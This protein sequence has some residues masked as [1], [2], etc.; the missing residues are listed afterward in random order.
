MVFEFQYRDI[1]VSNS[2]VADAWKAGDEKK[3][4][5]DILYIRAAGIQLEVVEGVCFTVLI[6]VDA[7]SDNC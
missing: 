1:I 2:Y 6:N 4:F 5:F 3:G 7:S